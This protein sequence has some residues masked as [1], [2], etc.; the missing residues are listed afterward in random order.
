[1]LGGEEA[2]RGTFQVQHAEHGLAADQGHGELALHL[3]AQVAAIAGI[4]LDVGDVEAFAARERFSADGAGGLHAG[5]HR[6]AAGGC[7]DHQLVSID[8]EQLA[9]GRA[10]GRER[11]IEKRVERGGV[12]PQHGLAEVFSAAPAQVCRGGLLR[13]NEAVL[14]RR[15]HVENA[16]D[17]LAVA[18]P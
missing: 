16:G 5:A 11:G 14:A 1:M 10:A 7:H 13:F 15:L 2:G 8:V 9:E 6:F 18:G 3:L 12:A 4:L 17:G